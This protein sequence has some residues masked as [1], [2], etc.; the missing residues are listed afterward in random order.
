MELAFSSIMEEISA[1]IAGFGS[2]EPKAYVQASPQTFLRVFLA[3]RKISGSRP[4]RLPGF[5]VLN[6]GAIR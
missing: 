4:G 2:N 6:C 5:K 3:L 1:I